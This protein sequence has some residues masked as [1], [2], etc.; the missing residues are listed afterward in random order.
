MGIAGPRAS[1]SAG[2]FIALLLTPW[3]AKAQDE[4]R[5]VSPNGEIEFRVFVG[6]P[7]DGLWPRIGYQV[8]F[9]GK[10]L[11]ATS[12]MGFDIRDQQP[13][14]GENA[15]LVSS[16]TASNKARHFNS[17][18]AHYMQNGSLGRRLD[19]E[20]RAYDDAV[21][22]RYLIPRSTPL[23]E[24]FI[25]DEATE[26]NLPQ[27]DLSHLAAKS[28]YNLPFAWK[29][30]GIGWIVI[31]T[32]GP[33]ASS[34]KYPRTDLVRSDAGLLTSLARSAE[35]S[36]VAFA[37]TTPSVWLWRVVM[38]GSDKERLMKSETLADLNR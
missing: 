2:L 4:R 9:R 23:K 20:I 3:A 8:A 14:L 29:E 36:S 37:G 30:P 24:L 34:G 38:A 11:I 10:P 31:T 12:W 15:G 17:L 21:A 19:I 7:K 25:Q 32:A 22:F 1:V 5:V 6:Q 33:E 18:M 27:G 13:L 16:E 35:D 28:D 26:F